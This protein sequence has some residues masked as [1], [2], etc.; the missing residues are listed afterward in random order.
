M[1]KERANDSKVGGFAFYL[2]LIFL[3]LLGCFSILFVVQ[4][5]QLFLKGHWL[6]FLPGLAIGALIGK[7]FIRGSLAVFIH[8]LKHSIVSNLAGNRA[9]GWKIKRHSGH[10]EY[11][12]TK[13]TSHY[14]AFI[15]LAPYYLPL[16]TLLSFLIAYAI[17]GESQFS[18][19]I[20]GI[21]YGIDLVLTTRDISPE[22][23][24][25]SNLRGGYG[26]GV[27]YVIAIQVII[28]I[29]VAT[30]VTNGANGL[31]LFALSLWHTAMQIS[32]GVVNRIKGA[33]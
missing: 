30:W 22:Q 29:L 17:S 6:G 20:V 10:F 14:N 28:M 8:E 18:A 1:A 12:Y 26:L 25:F 23:T 33:S 3:L 32:D 27:M 2:S 7:R 16:A 21:G 9:K 15:A 13:N 4:N 11:E 31:K 19:A 24:D 5:L